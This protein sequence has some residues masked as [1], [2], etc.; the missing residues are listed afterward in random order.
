MRIFG[1]ANK[2]RSTV[3]ILAAG[4]DD[5]GLAGVLRRA[6]QYVS[7]DLG[8][9]GPK[10]CPGAK[11]SWEPMRPLPSLAFPHNFAPMPA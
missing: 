7:F 11:R 10:A 6:M 4:A 9:Y 2:R 1:L 8:L 5:R 3:G